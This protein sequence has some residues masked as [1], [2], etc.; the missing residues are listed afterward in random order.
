MTRKTPT[1]PSVKPVSDSANLQG[2][3]RSAVTEWRFFQF[4]DG[5]R[6][7]SEENFTPAPP[8][9]APKN[10]SCVHE[11]VEDLID[12]DPDRSQTIYYCIHCL[13]TKS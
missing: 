9:Y 12:I 11:Y 13:D 10:P 8:V 5:Q 1:L 6:S 2:E 7:C 4:S 3:P